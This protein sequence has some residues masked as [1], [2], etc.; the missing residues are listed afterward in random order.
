VLI[1]VL[2]FSEVTIEK[3]AAHAADRHQVALRDGVA[4]HVRF[5]LV[6]RIPVGEAADKLAPGED[7]AQRAGAVLNTH[8]VADLQYLAEHEVAD[9]WRRIE[10]PDASHRC[11]RQASRRVGPDET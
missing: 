9:A 6:S 7:M 4:R 11:P 2:L 5:E 1:A 3:L 10:R 8:V